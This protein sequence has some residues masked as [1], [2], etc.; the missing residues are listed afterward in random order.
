MNK[1]MWL[2]IAN[3]VELAHREIAENMHKDPRGLANEAHLLLMTDIAISC[4]E[5]LKELRNVNTTI[6]RKSVNEY[7]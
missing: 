4:R 1:Q 6:N 7:P 5:I 2:L 3:R